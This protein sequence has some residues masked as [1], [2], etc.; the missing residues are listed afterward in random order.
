M[1]PPSIS[2]ISCVL[3]GL[4]VA[5]LGVAPALAQTPAA[6]QRPAPDNRLPIAVVDGRGVFARLGQDVLTA[7][8]LP[9]TALQLSSKAFGFAG[10]AHVYPWR[11]RS[12][13]FGVGGEAILAR[14]SFEPIDATTLKPGGTVFKRRLR[15]ASAQLSMNFGH[16]AGWS[17][18]TAGYGPLSFESYLSTRT[19]DGLRDATLNYGGGARWFNFDHLAF[20]LDLRFYATRPTLATPATAARARHRVFVMSAGIAI[21]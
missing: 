10:G 21:K 6:S 15:S 1:R 12:M 8:G 16:A 2:P 17:Y 3:I 11:G 14:N 5:A 19:P 13:A 18:L 20:T 7:A 9:T 4:V